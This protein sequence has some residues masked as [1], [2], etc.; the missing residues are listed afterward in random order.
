MLRNTVPAIYIGLA[1]HAHVFTLEPLNTKHTAAIES[2][3]KSS[4]VWHIQIMK[5]ALYLTFTCTFSLPVVAIGR[6]KPKQSCQQSG[7]SAVPGEQTRVWEAC[8]CHCGT[9]LAGLLTPNST[10]CMDNTLSAIER[11]THHV[12]K[13]KY[14]H[15]VLNTHLTL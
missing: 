9:E 10:R 13:F 12:K 14:I 1:P 15:I 3:Y 6:A 8:V 7:S 5:V 2:K 11:K 4:L